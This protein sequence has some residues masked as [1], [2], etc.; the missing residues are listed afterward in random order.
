MKQARIQDSMGGGGG[1]PSFR[2]RGYTGFDGGGGQ[3]P[4]FD[5]G[6]GAK[7]LISKFPQNHKGPP[8][9]ENRDLRFRGG[10]HGPLPPPVYGPAMKGGSTYKSGGS[11]PTPLLHWRL[12]DRFRRLRHRDLGGCLRLQLLAS[13]TRLHLRELSRVEGG[14][15]ELLTSLQQGRRWE[16]ISG[17]ADP[18]RGRS[19]PGTEPPK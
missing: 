5:D 10:G 9:C 14:G 16:K 2:R 6:G 7:A 15:L 3:C 17:G 8:L 1:M 19:R 12:S 18:F 13:G 11:T 4:V